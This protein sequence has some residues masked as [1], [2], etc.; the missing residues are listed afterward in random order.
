MGWYHGGKVAPHFDEA[1]VDTIHRRAAREHT[2]GSVNRR[3]IKIRS[4]QRNSPPM[5]A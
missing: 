1:W 2:L 5:A 4:N 3:G